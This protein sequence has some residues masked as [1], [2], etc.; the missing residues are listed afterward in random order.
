[1]AIDRF[2]RLINYLRISLTDHCNLRCLYCMSEGVKFIPNTK[3]MS[4]EEILVFVRLF[5][6]LGINKIR[7]TG[8][9]PTIRPG[10]IDLVREISATPGIRSVTMTTNGVIFSGI[11]HQLAEAGLKRVNFSLDTLD[12]DKYR[13]ITG[14]DALMEVLEGIR[15]AE[16]AGLTPVKINVVVVRDFNEEDVVEMARLTLENPWQVRFIEMMPFGDTQEFQ[17]SQLVTAN[18]IRER[19][20]VLLGGLDEYDGGKLEGEA[21]LFKVPGARGN[22]GFIST[23]TQPFCAYCDRVRL[24]ADGKFRLCLLS[25]FEVDLL[26]PMRG[27]MTSAELRG[28]ILE[29]IWNKPWG[30]RLAEGIVPENRVMSQIGG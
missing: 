4:D 8:G 27:G 2:G 11:A 24:T 19:I 5:A 6:S 15:A 10:V 30:N 21:R 20:E 23:V 26:G 29:S 28:I 3:L 17:F 9:E 16:E 1:M 25:E 18:E 14:R 12:M 22:I 7:L 13:Q